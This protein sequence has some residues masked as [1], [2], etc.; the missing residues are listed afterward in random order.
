MALSISHASVLRIAVPIMLSNVSE[1]LI[2]VVNTAVMGRLPEPH[3]IGAV[4]VGSLI[5]SFLFWGFGFLRLSTSGLSAQATGAGDALS[6]TQIFWRSLALAVVIGVAL[7]AAGP[8]LGTY[9]IA[10]VGG[11]DAVMSEART[12]FNYRIWSAP[13]ALCNFVIAG[14]FIGQGR[15]TVAFV[16]QLFLNVTNMVLSAVFVLHYGMTTNGVGLSVVIAEYAAVGVGLVFVASALTRLGIGFDGRTIFQ[17][18]KIRAMI[19]ANTDIMIRTFALVFAFGWFTSRG[20]HGGDLVIAAN[21]VLL[22]LFEVAAFL[23]DGFAYAAEALVGQAIGAKD[24]VQFGRAIS[25]T[26]LW[27]MVLGVLCSLLIWLFGVEL[28]G[29]ITTNTAVREAAMIY[30]PWAALTPVLGTVCFQFD[31][32]FTGAMATRDM[33]NMMVVSLVIYL[34][35]G[36]FLEARFG[37]HG[38]WMALCVFFIARGVSFAWRMP[39]IAARAFA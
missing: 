30:L 3:Y 22:L 19:A 17:G 28:V 24:R 10:L 27:A 34:V 38:L 9:A 37:N 8:V 15:S 11:S 26:T 20:A 25:I 5:V 14:W 2:G 12:Y 18:S 33:R 39:G 31:G 21:S 1:P 6:L 23:I 7:V 36:Y 35:A 13:A 29:L 32:I 16:T 4:T